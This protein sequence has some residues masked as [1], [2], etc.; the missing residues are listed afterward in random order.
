MARWIEQVAPKQK[1]APQALF[2]ITGVKAGLL[3][4]PQPPV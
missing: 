3:P 4:Q 2:F 1:R